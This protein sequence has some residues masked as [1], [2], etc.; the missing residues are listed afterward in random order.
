[1][2]ADMEERY[3]ALVNTGILEP[4]RA[5]AKAVQRLAALA[6]TLRHTSFANKTSAL[7][8]L[9]AKKA[10]STAPIQGLYIWGDVGRGKTMLMDLFFDSLPIASKR[11]VHFHA[12]MQD[13]HERVHE[14]RQKLRNNEV[15][16]D[17]PIAPIASDLAA[18]A[19]VLCFDEFAVTDIA[20]AMILARLFTQLY[21]R[22]VVV[23]AT[24]NVPPDQLYRDGLNRALFLPFIAMLTQHMQVLH[25]EART[26]FRLEKLGDAPVWLAPI[27]P[28]TEAH[29]DTLWH[30][31]TAGHTIKEETLIVHQ[32]QLHVPKAAAGCARFHFSEIIAPP[33]HRQLMGTA[34]FL[35]LA[36]QYHTLFIDHIHSIDPDERN[37]AKRFITLI[38]TLYDHGV[39]LI[40]SAHIQL[41]EIYQATSGKEAFEIQ[42]TISRLMEMRSHSYLAQPHIIYGV[43]DEFI[44]I[45]T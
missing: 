36:R 43:N 42:R 29:L 31:L 21:A 6:T 1:M 5:Q 26:D 27:S 45:E 11:R 13:V 20:D 15:K 12:F 3:L 10:S 4:D 28:E 23:V 35:A 37:N 19:R 33:A 38:D 9:F 22:G 25:L 18:A 8:W 39:K 30:K 34:D 40:A 41:H 44:G 32:R 2:P 7:G 24:S 16:G 17:D 14:Y